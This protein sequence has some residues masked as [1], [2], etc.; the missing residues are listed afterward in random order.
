MREQAKDVLYAAVGA[1]DVAVEK[2]KGTATEA[3][4]VARRARKRAGSAFDK[5]ERRGRTVAKRRR[6]AKRT[7]AVAARKSKSARSP[8]SGATSTRRR[9]NAKGRSGR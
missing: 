1:A 7:A 6:P 2:V 4:K 8:R 3:T 9:V 5:A